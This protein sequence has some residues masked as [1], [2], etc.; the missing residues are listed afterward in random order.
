MGEQLNLGRVDF[1]GMEIM[2][3]SDTSLEACR[4]IQL[5]PT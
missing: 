5:L 2:H 1:W 4:E 3:V